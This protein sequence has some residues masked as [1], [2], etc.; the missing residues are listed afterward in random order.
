VSTA[1][2]P[3][4]IVVGTAH[5]LDLSTP[6]RVALEGQGLQGIAVELDPERAQT[7]LAEPQTTRG[8]PQGVPLLLRLWGIL[9]KR[10]GEQLGIGAGAEMR[11]AAQLAREW[12]IPLLLIDDP[13]RA[14]IARLLG[15]LSFRERVQLVAGGVLGLF[16][17]ARVVR[18]QIGEYSRASDEYLSEIRRVYPTVGRV[19]LDDR[20]EHMAERLAAIRT[21]G[22]GRVAAVVGDAHVSG[23]SQALER[24]GIPTRQVRLKELTAATA[25]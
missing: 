4:I 5:V 8:R 14:T 23:L 21:Q 19:L 24:R 10:L 1:G 6:L 15:S 2:G 25:Q 13:V 9:Q 12:R 18:G 3:A 20:N 17:P 11:V 22:L 16:L 7:V